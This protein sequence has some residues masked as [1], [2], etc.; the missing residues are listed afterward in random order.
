MISF[1]YF[2]IPITEIFPFKIKNI[3]H[4]SRTIWAAGNTEVTDRDFLVSQCQEQNDETE[5]SNI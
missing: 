3:E 2:V 4:M 1:S 5:T